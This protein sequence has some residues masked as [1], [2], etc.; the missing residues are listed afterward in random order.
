MNSTRL[1]VGLLVIY[2]AIAGFSIYEKNLGKTLYWCGAI[3]LLIGVL[4]M[5][6]K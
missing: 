6:P 2:V 4:V 1:T 3:M 5:S